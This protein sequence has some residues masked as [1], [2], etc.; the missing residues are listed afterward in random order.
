MLLLVA[1]ASV[2]GAFGSPKV[3]SPPARHVELRVVGPDGT[4]LRGAEVRHACED[5]HDRPIRDPAAPG[6][7]R[8]GLRLEQP[9]HASEV[10]DL[11]RARAFAP[12]GPLEWP[13]GR[14]LLV[15]AR[16]GDSW[17]FAWFPRD[18]RE[19]VGLGHS[20][21]PLTI[22][23]A[24]DWD[25]AVEVLDAAGQPVRSTAMRLLREEG[26]SHGL[27]TDQWPVVFEHLGFELRHDRSA[28]TIRVDGLFAA[29]VEARVDPR[30][31][32]DGPLVLRLPPTGS[33]ELV[34]QD[35]DGLPL[36]REWSVSLGRAGREARSG[37]YSRDGRIL[38]PLVALGE[39]LDVRFPGR[40]EDE[41]EAF[42]GPTWAGERVVRTLL[43]PRRQAPQPA[44]TAPA[45]TVPTGSF[46]GRLLLEEGVPTSALEVE[47]VD[48]LERQSRHRLN[49]QRTGSFS[50]DDVPVGRYRLEITAHGLLTVPEHGR[51]YLHQA[52]LELA[53]GV[54]QELAMLDLRGKLFLH[55]VRFGGETLADKECV[56]LFGP[57]TWPASQRGYLRLPAGAP[58]LVSAWPKVD[59]ELFVPG[60]RR[61]ELTDLGAEHTVTL[62]PGLP[63]ALNL[64][65][66]PV[67]AA[68]VRLAAVLM[69]E[70]SARHAIDWKAPT[71][72][73]GRPLE[74]TAYAPGPNRVLWVLTRGGRGQMRETAEPQL[75][76]VR[77]LGLRQSFTLELAPEELAGWIAEF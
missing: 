44:H 9:P 75:V 38:F 59:V 25:L 23:V 18:W 70:G 46:H 32:P 28:A 29:P 2:L 34:L 64:V 47:L 62:E 63:V 5:E 57:R 13:A 58:V 74:T 11:L 54:D 30:R 45:L 19:T 76:D 55:R 20:G 61:V 67:P 72:E 37:R 17:G 33:V 50:A 66:V 35:P 52:E 15:E 41:P 8:Q 71:F 12:V 22:E 68:P 73:P 39:T 14:G 7:F 65:G 31:R 49:L 60:Y 42:A 21:E 6:G 53:A 56:A 1:F 69:P 48:P 40:I 3:S 16:H 51:P 10:D 24:P 36:E 27:S 77:D 26:G 43:T 4:A